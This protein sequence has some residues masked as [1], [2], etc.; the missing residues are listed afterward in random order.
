[1]GAAVCVLPS[2]GTV[3]R[4]DGAARL[5]LKPVADLDEALVAGGGALRQRLADL[6]LERAARMRADRV[7]V[8]ERVRRI[9]AAATDEARRTVGG[10]VAFEALPLAGV[11]GGVDARVDAA[12]LVERGASDRSAVD[13]SRV[14]R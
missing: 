9:V 12:S 1:M 6:Q 2:S 4:R 5:Q 8:A 14:A 7:L 11:R 10:L 13:P 3:L